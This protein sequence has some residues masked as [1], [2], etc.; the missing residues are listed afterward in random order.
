[1]FV[2]K[3]TVFLAFVLQAAASPHKL[4]SLLKTSDGCPSGVHIV[5]V[6][7]TLED[8]GFG[9][10]QDIVDKVLEQI[11]NSDSKAIDYPASG[12]TIAADGDP[13][14]NFFQYR[15]SVAM[16]VDKFSAEIQDFTMECPDTGIVVMGYS[17]ASTVDEF[18]LSL[19]D[20]DGFGAGR[21]SHGYRHLRLQRSHL[22]TEAAV[23]L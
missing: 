7:G 2:K 4:Q 8:P 16:G 5:G 1:M 14:Y 19:A 23:E 3:S 22:Y 17:Q 13:V 21:S 11:P 6:R 20:I 9:A 12:I 15:S 10:M 18:R